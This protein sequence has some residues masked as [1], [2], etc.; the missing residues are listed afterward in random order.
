MRILVAEDDAPLAEF[1][2]QRLVQ[3]RFA[4]QLVSDGV[5]AQRLAVEQ[6]YDL[7]LLDLSR[8][9][10]TSGLDVL[11]NIRLKKPDLP[12]L[13]ITAASMVEERVRGLDAGADDYIAKP[14]AFAELAARIRA[15]LRRGGRPG[16]AV[17]AIDD[18]TVDRVSHAVQRAGHAIDLSPKEFALLEFLMR[19]AGQPVTRSAIVEQVWKLNFDTMTNV[20]DVYINYL[21]RKVDTGH[22]R[23]LIRTV[24]G[25]GYQ[26]GGAAGA[27]RSAVVGSAVLV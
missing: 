23:P 1:L 13:I 21:R 9:E 3:E 6:S 17:L 27:A 22:D 19:H 12:V 8:P 11:R 10:E 5:E 14:F 20:V 7:V 2:H 26:I 16:N 15:V 24:R 4:V 25:V 18:L